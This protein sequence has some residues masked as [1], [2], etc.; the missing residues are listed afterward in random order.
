MIAVVVNSVIFVGII[1]Q[2]TYR[3]DNPDRDA[4]SFAIFVLTA[5]FLKNLTLPGSPGFIEYPYPV[6]TGSGYMNFRRLNA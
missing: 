1:N 3:I 5:C 4:D 2:E 6:S